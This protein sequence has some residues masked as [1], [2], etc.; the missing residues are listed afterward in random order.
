VPE[1][2]GRRAAR[3]RHHDTFVDSAWYFLRFASNGND[4]A[5][6]DAR[7]DYW[8][9]VDQYI[10]GIEHAILHLLY[11]RFWTKV[12]R[13][14]GLVKA[15]EPFAHLLTQGMVLN[16]IYFRKE[17]SGRLTWFNPA[18]V[19]LEH[20]AEGRPL[21]ARLKATASRSRWAAWARCRS[22]RTTR[23]SAVMVD[24]YGADTVRCY[25]MFTSAPEDT[26]EWS[27]A[28]IEGSVRFSE[29]VEARARARCGRARRRLDAGGLDAAQRKL[30]RRCTP[31]CRKSA[32][33]SAGA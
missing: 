4:R 8:T 33:T 27:D 29:A 15:D 10:G 32:T 21:R 28:S 5:M 11:A 19:E 25:M 22:R 2:Q 12:M 26:L 14:F 3:D 31:R 6:V 7:A 9:P 24:R 13:D 1:V 30:R 18:D 23:G 17:E 20:D 16:H